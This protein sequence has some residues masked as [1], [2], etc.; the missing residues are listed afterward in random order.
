MVPVMLFLLGATFI[1]VYWPARVQPD[2]GRGNLD[3]AGDLNIS[4]YRIVLSRSAYHT[5]LSRSAYHTVLS[6]SAA[7]WVDPRKFARHL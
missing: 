4:A 5:V 7:L 2:A 1:A 3:G 6:R